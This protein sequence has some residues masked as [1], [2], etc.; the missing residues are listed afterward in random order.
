MYILLLL[1]WT[2][3]YVAIVHGRI[4][5][6]YKTRIYQQFNKITFI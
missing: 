6:G 2:S 3:L 4:S 1:V 5:N